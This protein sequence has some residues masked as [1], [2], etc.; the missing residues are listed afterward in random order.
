MKFVRHNLTRNA[1]LYA[2]LSLAL[3]ATWVIFEGIVLGRVRAFGI[4]RDYITP[5]DDPIQFYAIVF[6]AFIAL[7]FF[8]WIGAGIF[9]MDREIKRKYR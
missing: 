4:A 6:A 8:S 3:G 2:A 1:G 5:A 9:R 7:G